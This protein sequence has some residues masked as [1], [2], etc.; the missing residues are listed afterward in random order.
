MA[1]KRPRFSVGVM[2][3]CCGFLSLVVMAREATSAPSTADAPGDPSRKYATVHQQQMHPGASTPVTTPL[4]PAPSQIV[5]SKRHRKTRETFPPSRPTTTGEEYGTG[6][7]SPERAPRH[8]RMEPK[9]G[10]L[11]S[12]LVFVPSRGRRYG[13]FGVPTEK[14]Q[15][16][17]EQMLEKGDY[18]VPN[19]GKKAP[20]ASSSELMIKK[21][22]FDVLL[23]GPGSPD[24]YFFP[25]RGKKEY[26]LAYD[27]IGSVRQ[28]GGRDAFSSFEGKLAGAG[29]NRLRRNLLENLANDHKDTFFSSRGK[30][31]R[32]TTDSMVLW[33]GETLPPVEGR[34][35]LP[36][37]GGTE[38][39]DFSGQQP[40]IEAAALLW[41]DAIPLYSVER[42]S[43]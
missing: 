15:L 26:F 14:R 40:D 4:S 29:E 5:E 11:S 23:G 12:R 18:F 25:N 8:R 13:G 24:E 16:T 9:M 20:T 27:P 1:Q 30:R 41:N 22:K 34:E 2:A 31:I 42:P 38:S 28:S 39:V 17:I 7:G 6:P 21:G 10:S 33:P 43:S 32:P 35:L 36:N 37:D 3:M 19:R